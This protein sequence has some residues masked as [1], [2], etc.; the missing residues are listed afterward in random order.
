MKLIGLIATM[1][2]FAVA[3][4]TVEAGRSK[5]QTSETIVTESIST[6]GTGSA[7]SSGRTK[8]KHR[9]RTKTTSTGSAG[10]R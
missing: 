1:I 8:H 6:S 10:S 7:G 4:E 2:I 5:V 9:H 3:I